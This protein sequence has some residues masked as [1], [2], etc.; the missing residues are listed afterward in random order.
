[1]TDVVK[2]R[3][4]CTW[5]AAERAEWLA[6]F[7]QS[8]KTLAEFCRDNGLAPATLSFWRTHLQGKAP[9]GDA[10]ALVEVSRTTLSTIGACAAV[11]ALV[12]LQLRGGLRLEIP[13]GTDPVWVG[14][15]VRACAPGR[16]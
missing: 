11:P 4:R 2:P 8:G 6:L 1:M 3:S 16:T 10:A 13:P 14:E 7:E 9:A 12:I 5:T 15:L